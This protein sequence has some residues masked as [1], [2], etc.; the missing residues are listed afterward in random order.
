MGGKPSTA[1]PRDMRL[2]ENKAQ[3]GDASPKPAAKASAKPAGLPAGF[4]D[5]PWD[6]SASRWPD[7][8]SY[9]ASC[10]INTNTGP[11]ANWTKANAKLPV[12]EPDGTVNVN[13]LHAAASVLAGGQGGVSASPADK[14]SAAK[15]LKGYYAR[16]GESLP[17]S[18]KQMAM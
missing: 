10:L 15:R 4:T 13:A 11:K 6:G 1:T 7:A 3:A 9:A 16:L 14:K 17:P 18:I 2:K 8:A 12:Q 5:K